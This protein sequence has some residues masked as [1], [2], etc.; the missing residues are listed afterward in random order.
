ML[1]RRLTPSLRLAV[2]LAVAGFAT[3][4]HAD[5][6][7]D[8]NSGTILADFLFDDT[9]GTDIPSVVNSSPLSGMFDVDD[10]NA[11]VVTDGTGYLDASG[12]ANTEF[13]T[14]YVDLPT[15][16]AAAPGRVIGL[17]EVTWAF[18][19]NV[20][21]PSQ[22][23]EFRLSLITF[24]PRSTF[25]TGETF[26]VRTSATEV[27]MYGNAVGTG[28]S[29]TSDIILGSSGSL[30]TLIDI[31]LGADTLELFYSADGGL[32]FLSAG[33]GALDPSRGIESLRLVLNEDYTD[34]TLL[35]DRVAV[36]LVPEP[37]SALLAGL[38]AASVAGVRR[39]R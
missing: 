14:S 19:E 18:D 3:A 11:D 35:I 5:I 33:V 36:S 6:L 27:T 29:D 38:A 16:N 13:G 2:V 20:Y 28:A 26:F 23:E 37:A 32:T 25:V 34:D 24:V 22:D 17:F 1:W 9:A 21:D 31:D 7:D 15:I 10:D 39:R 30:L 12:K 4:S 8:F